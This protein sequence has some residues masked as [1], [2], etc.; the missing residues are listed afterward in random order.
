MQQ[1][2]SPEVAMQVLRDED[3]DLGPPLDRTVAIVAASLATGKVL[4]F[5]HGSHATDRG[6]PG[7]RA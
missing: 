2:R 1:S 4:D 3:A 6:W 7:I 5:A